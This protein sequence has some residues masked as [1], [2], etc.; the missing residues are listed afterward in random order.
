MASITAVTSETIVINNVAL[1]P[2]AGDTTSSVVDLRTKQCAVLHLSLV[3]GAT[4]PSTEAQL[5]I[6]TGSASDNLKNYGGPL[7]GSKSNGATESWSIELPIGTR[8]LQ[9]IGTPGVAQNVTANVTLG[10]IDSQTIA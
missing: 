9:V 1:V 10:T 7:V 8:Y 3:N 6:K 5:Q 2:G 4:G